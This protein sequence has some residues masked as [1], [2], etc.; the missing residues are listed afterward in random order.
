M[1]V[2]H[3]SITTRSVALRREVKLEFFL[4]KNFLSFKSLHLLILNDG[5]D[6]EILRIKESLERLLV[7][8]SIYPTVVVAVH[9]SER[10]E[11]YGTAGVLDYKKRGKK[12]LAYQKFI[13]E[14]LIPFV[15]STT[16]VM[17]FASTGIAG[18]SLGALSALNTAWNHHQKFHLVGAFSGAFWWRSVDLGKNYKEDQ[19]RIIHKL[20]KESTQKPVMRFW[21]EA[22]T[23]D[24]KVDRNKNGVI[25][26]I[27][28][29]LDLIKILEEK[30]YTLNEELKY[31]EVKNGE[32]NYRTWSSI[33][34]EFLRW[35]FGKKIS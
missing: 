28:D 23:N 32:H 34:P 27:D 24:E 20:I 2:I 26:A 11:E 5:Q 6:C 13:T 22:G 7:T 8:D 12:S 21:F 25:D 14:E 1:S 31:V 9:P 29:T 19:H 17:N 16:K 35:A 10:V 33:F 18:F 15:S 30:G 3:Q 4:P